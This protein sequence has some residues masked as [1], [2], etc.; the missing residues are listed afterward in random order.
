VRAKWTRTMA[1]RLQQQALN[2]PRRP[3]PP[4]TRVKQSRRG[5]PAR[6]A[7]HRKRGLE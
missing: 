1:S 3:L 4:P 6:K 7:K 2:L 5:E